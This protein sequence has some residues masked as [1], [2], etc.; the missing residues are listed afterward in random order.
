MNQ[1]RKR[2]LPFAPSNNNSIETPFISNVFNIE[3]TRFHL[4]TVLTFKAFF[5]RKKFCKPLLLLFEL[6]ADDSSRLSSD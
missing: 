6:I 1:K 4:E 5:N 3:A 2:N